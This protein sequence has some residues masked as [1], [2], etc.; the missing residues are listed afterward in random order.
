M[1]GEIGIVK[2]IEFGIVT[3][4]FIQNDQIVDINF[5]KSQLENMEYGYACTCHKLQGIGFSSVIV[6]MGNSFCG[7]YTREWFYTAVTRAKKN[8][9]IFT[10]DT[11][12]KHAFYNCETNKKQTF[13]EAMLNK[14][15]RLVG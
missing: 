8:V 2:K 7:M 5:E 3:I 10:T 14:D 13:L 15:E 1:N 9:K 4:A 12:L 6:G 11:A